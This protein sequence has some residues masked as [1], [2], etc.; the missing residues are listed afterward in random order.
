MALLR[1]KESQASK[2]LELQILTA[3]RPGEVMG[4]TW[5]EFDIKSKA[6]T[7]SAERMKASKE[8]TIPLS[9]RAIEILKSLPRACDFVFPSPTLKKP[10]TTAA[11]MKLIKE[12]LP[13]VTA[14]GM[15]SIFRDWAA[16]QTAFP[17]EVIEHALAH[18]LKDKAEAAHLRSDLMPKRAKLMKAWAEYC[19]HAT[20]DKD[21]VTP[22]N[23]GTKA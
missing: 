16:D 15:R 19:N 8:H 18:Q 14:H 5:D 13:G 21:N 2:A 20:S 10:M 7:I 12:I 11:G 4:A 6:W 3:T 1:E 23:K 17:R 9:N 22:T